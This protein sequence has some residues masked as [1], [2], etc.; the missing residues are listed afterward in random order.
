MPESADAAQQRAQ[1]KKARL[2]V[3]PPEPSEEFSDYTLAELR[4]LRA[5]LTDYE[6]RVS[7]WRR[8]VQARTDLARAGQQPEDRD[9][10]A[11]ALA[12]APSRGRRIANLDLF[13]SDTTPP[14]P[15]L[16]ELWESAPRADEL[17]DYLDR[18][19][20]IERDLSSHRRALHQRI[21]ALHNE[22][23]ARYRADPTLALSALP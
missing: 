16:N 4:R 21:D 14:L 6:T 8:L 2:A 9:R 15:E 3:P 22:L 20:R 1:R 18:L 5:E 13:P 11:H 23:I 17:D 19:E 10:L 12:D 7:Y